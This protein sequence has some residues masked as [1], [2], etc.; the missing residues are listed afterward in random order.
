M[1]DTPEDIRKAQKKYLLIGL[2]LFVFTVVTVAVATV[3]WL[4]FGEHGFDA[5]DAIIGLVIATIKA[6]L[7]GAIFMHLSNEKKTIY[8]LIV[9]GVMMGI[10]LMGLIGWTYNNPIEYGN[11]VEGDGFFN[12]EE[13]AKQQ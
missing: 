6:S 1:A 5:W 10:A 13:T 9:M 4:D 11:S 8:V 3:P 2:I 12:P 7:V